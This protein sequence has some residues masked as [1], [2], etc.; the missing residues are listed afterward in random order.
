MSTFA[1]TT[2]AVEWVKEHTN[3]DS[4]ELAKLRGLDFQFVVPKNSVVE[5]EVVLYFPVD[6]LLPEYIL[7]YLNL[8]GKLS[9]K[10]KN[11]VKTIKLRGEISQGIIVPQ[12]ELG[13]YPTH[14]VGLDLTEKLGVI[15]Y[16]PPEM[17]SKNARTMTL[18]PE[19]HV[20]DI[21][22]CERFPDVAEALM[23]IPVLVTEK[24]EGSNYAA[25]L[26]K[27]GSFVVCTRRQQVEEL[28]GYTHTWWE[29]TRKQN[30]KWFCEDIMNRYGGLPQFVTIRGEVIGPGIQGNYYGLTQ[31][32]LRIFDIDVDGTPVDASQ[33]LELMEDRPDRVP[34]LYFSGTLRAYLKD[35]TVKEMSTDKSRLAPDKLREGIVIRPMTEQRHPKLGRVILKQRSPEYLLKS[36][37]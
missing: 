30:I 25:M 4:L 19:L 23:D 32:E 31:H 1:V 36:D 28:E 34:E 27:D 13:L 20:Y 17:I 29:V 15:K 5:E 16:E 9:G 8:T 18:P 12:F 7:E 33:Y 14:T 37:T 21:E 26:R 3:A 10:D 22:G 11:R 35:K 24:L 6:S 2:E